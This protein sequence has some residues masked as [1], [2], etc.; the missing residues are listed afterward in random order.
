MLHDGH[1]QGVVT[2]QARLL[3]NDGGGGNQIGG[4]GENLDLT[5]QHFLDR[6]AEPGKLLDLGPMLGQALGNSRPG[7][8]KGID[9]L[10]GHEPMGEFTQYVSRGKT[11]EVL[12]LDAVE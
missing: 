7:S 12:V 3:A 5:L 9:G 1:D 10:G 6:P 4:N 8:S 11:L 2:Q